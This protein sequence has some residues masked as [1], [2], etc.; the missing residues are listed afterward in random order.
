[1]IVGHTALLVHDETSAQ[2][3]VTLREPQGLAVSHETLMRRVA[4]QA[5]VRGV[6]IDLAQVMRQAQL[7]GAAADVDV[8]AAR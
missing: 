7:Q 1:M 2:L 4:V 8:G 5:L 6:V 3:G